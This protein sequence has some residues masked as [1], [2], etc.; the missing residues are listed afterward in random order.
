MADAA[1]NI[2]I[3]VL[4]DEAKARAGLK[5]MGDDAEQTESRW[6]K[7]GTGIKAGI[8]L[9]GAAVLSF[10]ADAVKAASRRRESAE[11]SGPPVENV[12]GSD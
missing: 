5:R 1:R 12:D 8:A 2:T 11:G 10:A 7:M 6:S 4:L 3:K 9:A